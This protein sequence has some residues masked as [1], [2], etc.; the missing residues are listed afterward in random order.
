MCKRCGVSHNPPTGKHCRQARI[1]EIEQEHTGIADLIPMISELQSQMAELRMTRGETAVAEPQQ[2]LSDS[3]SSGRGETN[4][5][6]ED[7]GASAVA[8][9]ETLRKDRRLMRRA[10]ER[11]AQ[12]G[13]DDSEDDS[14]QD[15]DRGRR[16]GK[17]SGA[18]LTTAEKVVKRID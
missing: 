12:L 11:L 5:L 17:K 15:L 4:S 2:A 14:L 9:P 6:L 18:I 8:S 7:E 13:T 3:T 16:N 10:A 1:T